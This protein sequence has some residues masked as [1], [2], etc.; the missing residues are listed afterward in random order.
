[1]ASTSSA[2]QTMDLLGKE[3]DDEKNARLQ[4]KAAFKEN[5][6]DQ[7]AALDP[8]SEICCQ[9]L[10]KI[11]CTLTPLNSSVEIIESFLEAGLSTV[12]LPMWEFSYDE[13]FVVLRNI[14]EAVNI[15]SAKHQLAYPL[16][17]G[18]DLR[19][20]TVHIGRLLENK[21][22]TVR[23]GTTLIL[24]T[25]QIW[26][27]T[28][29]ANKV[30]IDYPDLPSIVKCGT[31]IFIDSGLISL[32]VSHI[33]GEE[34]IVCDV[35]KGG[36]LHNNR[37]VQVLEV[38]LLIKELP[39]RDI[40][41]IEFAIQMELDFIS[42]SS[43]RFESVIKKKV[44]KS[45]I[46]LVAKIQDKVAVA[47]M[48]QIIHEADIVILVR[49]CVAVEMTKERTYLIQDN[50][51][52][53]CKML[54]KPIFIQGGIVCQNFSEESKLSESFD[55]TDV[56]TI[57][58]KGVD[59]FVVRDNYSLELN[60]KTLMKE[61]FKISVL[62]EPCYWQTHF[63]SKLSTMVIPPLDP[64]H[65]MSIAIVEAAMKTGAAAIL[66]CTASGASAR[67]VCRYIP[68]MPVIAITRYGRVARQLTLYRAAVPFQYIVPAVKEWQ[69]DI[70]LRFQAGIDFGK[71]KGIIKAGDVLLL[72]NGWRPGAGFTNTM[73]MIYASRTDTW[74]HLPNFEF[75][76]KEIDNVKS[77]ANS[78]CP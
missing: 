13:K 68:R 15:F 44:R 28:G 47:N 39:D 36:K 59:G 69:N 30:F 62:A 25:K 75:M 41:D 56:F 70:D 42:L 43:I 12:M 20:P 11:I 17:I 60:I 4:M 16:G 18:I 67:L 65:A 66:V 45:G 48:E 27:N 50:M 38:P 10:S 5:L 49:N 34:E 33:L 35:I 23:T 3:K 61:F 8:N 77:P 53:I 63:F 6:L 26:Q 76:C 78:E 72:L 64:A 1:M 14:R 54:G 24:T 71:R 55:Y 21:P 31:D 74:V 19:G 58:Q 9:T 46:L 57:L 52:A 2:K 32:N 22:V 73:R 37:I 40:E 29:T 51:I 7:M